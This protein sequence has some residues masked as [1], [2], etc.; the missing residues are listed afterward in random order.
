VPTGGATG[1][2]LTKIDATNY[3]TQWQKPFLPPTGAMT[4]AMLEGTY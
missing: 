4:Y 1:Q 3:N 2:M